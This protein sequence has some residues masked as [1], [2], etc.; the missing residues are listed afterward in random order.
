VIQE[1]ATSQCSF[2]VSGSKRPF[3]N[4]DSGDSTPPPVVQ[5]ANDFMD[6]LRDITLTT[7]FLTESPTPK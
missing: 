3:E 6:V 4:F 2:F 1:D 5:K 7:E